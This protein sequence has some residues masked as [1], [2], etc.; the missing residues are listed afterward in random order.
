[1][2]KKSTKKKDT[3]INAGLRCLNSIKKLKLEC[4][5]QKFTFMERMVDE[6]YHKFTDVLSLIDQE[7]F[8]TIKPKRKH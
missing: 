1:M 3:K 5:Y 6:V 7:T 8:K 4:Q 2:A